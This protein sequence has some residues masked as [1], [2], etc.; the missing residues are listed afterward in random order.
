MT[1]AD[2]WVIFRLQGSKIGEECLAKAAKM[3]VVNVCRYML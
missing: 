3:S 2:A 1:Y